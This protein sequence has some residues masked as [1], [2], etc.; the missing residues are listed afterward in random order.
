[1][2]SLQAPSYPSANSPLVSGYTNA[3]AAVG[4]TAAKT[5]NTI[6]ADNQVTP[7]GSL[8]YT[9]NANGS[10]TATEN[11]TPAEQGLVT[12]QQNLAA[13][14]QQKAQGEAANLPSTPL[15][16]SSSA[17]GA[18][19]A[20]AYDPRLDLQ[21][22]QNYDAQQ[23]D[24]KNRGI[25]E[26]SQAYNMAMQQFD[27]AKNDAYN[28]VAINA[29]GEAVSEM[30]AQHASPYSDI[31]SLES[32]SQPIMPSFNATPQAGVAAPNVAGAAAGPYTAANNAYQAQLAQQNA[33]MGG[34]AGLGGSVV[35]G[36]LG[37]PIGAGIGSSL[38]GGIGGGSG[39]AANNT[40]GGAGPGGTGGLYVGPGAYTPSDRRLKQDIKKVGKLDD[41]TN[42][43]SY[44]YKGGGLS[45]LGVMAQEVEKKYPEAVADMP[46]GF[47][48]VNYSELAD[49][50]A[51]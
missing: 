42:V 32:G 12:G 8:T 14:L 51:A 34:L 17:I 47:K 26:G 15:D 41:G 39:W 18:D 23:A 10:M 49:R 5:Q 3:Q 24:L 21:W 28:Q 4:T 19:I 11:L 31:A 45:Q 33:M 2:K 46:S 16:L 6:N 35:G 22:Q 9:P 40:F 38:G 36:V 7:Y 25:N 30:E 44:K 48:G 27:Q 50:V 37:G 1:M 13:V 29:R 20:K 43:Y